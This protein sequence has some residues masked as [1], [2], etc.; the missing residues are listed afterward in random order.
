MVYDKTVLPDMTG[1]SPDCGISLVRFDPGKE[2]DILRVRLMLTIW[3][4]LLAAG[5]DL[6]GI[7]HCL[8]KSRSSVRPSVGDNYT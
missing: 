6:S 8:R 1:A 2:M 3:L 7:I 5:R 4:T